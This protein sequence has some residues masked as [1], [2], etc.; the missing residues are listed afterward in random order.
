MERK[1]I[2]SVLIVAALA[3]AAIFGAV[4]S[5]TVAAQ[6]TTPT[7]PADASMPQPPQDR[8]PRGDRDGGMGDQDLAA[9]LGIDVATLQTA[10]QTADAEA[11]KQAVS[12]GLLTQEEA[13]QM[14]ANQINGAA[15][16]PAGRPAGGQG[17]MDW[18][19][20]AGIDREA[21]LAKALGISTDQLQAAQQKAFETGLDRAVTDGKMTQ[22]QADL[23]KARNALVANEKFQ[24]SM[25][26]AYQA[27]VQ[28]AV[29]DGVLT[30]TQA[31]Q[32]LKDGAGMGFAG[33]RGGPGGF[34]PHGR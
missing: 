21:L 4:T 27:A 12:A 9:A 24:A 2:A 34:G 11:L 13:D 15:G 32:I 28:Q 23:M 1:T 30:Q 16:R 29:T 10:R 7:A 14:T 17:R 6:A 26:S 25:Q 8:G 3:I 5:H 31:D 22:D 20:D 33:G 19:G 18:R